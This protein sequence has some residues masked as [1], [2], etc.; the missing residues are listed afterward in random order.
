[1]NKVALAAALGVPASSISRWLG[2]KMPR[3]ETVIRIAKCLGVDAN[4]LL[5]GEGGA[6]ADSPESSVVREDVIPYGAK[7]K[8]EPLRGPGE[9]TIQERLAAIEKNDVETRERLAAIQAGLDQ[10]I[11]LFTNRIPKDES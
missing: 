6:N 5:T 9:P 10:L 2:G 4:W 11:D 3:S 8:P 1:M 7:P